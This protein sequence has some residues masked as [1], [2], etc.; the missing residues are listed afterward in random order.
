MG[1]RKIAIVCVGGQCLFVG[2]IIRKILYFYFPLF[3]L[4]IMSGG[5]GGSILAM[6]ISLKNNKAI[7]PKRKSFRDI[8]EIYTNSVSHYQL[9]KKK[10]DPEF[11]KILRKQ[12]IKE[13]RLDFTKRIVLICFS[14]AIAITLFYIPFLVIKNIGFTFNQKSVEESTTNRKKE[15]Y[16]NYK[17]A[18]YYGNNH[19][20]HKEYT[21]AIRNYKLALK[22]SPNKYQ[23]YYDLATIYYFACLDSNIYCQEAIT[24]LSGIIDETDTSL[25]AL[26][27]RSEILMHT[28]EFEKAESDLNI[29]DRNK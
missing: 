2:R 17:M 25:Y 3:Y 13:R 28:S 8:R 5:A 22:F 21:L 20:K 9:N 12:L 23:T 19:F 15:I 29:I 26:K 6:I 18:L 27:L 24:I 16:K 7:L 10:S 1:V 4:N 11:L 14:I